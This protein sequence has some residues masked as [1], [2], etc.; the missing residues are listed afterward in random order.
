MLRQRYPPSR[1]GALQVVRIHS[2]EEAIQTLDGGNPLE[3]GQVPIRQKVEHC[4]TIHGVATKSAIQTRRPDYLLQKI[5]T[6]LYR[7]AVER[8]KEASGPAYFLFG[9]RIVFYSRCLE[10]LESVLVPT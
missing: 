9:R 2:K 3:L 1:L 4:S 5:R 8:W 10:L 6:T 7:R